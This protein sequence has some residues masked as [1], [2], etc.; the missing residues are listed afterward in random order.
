MRK[1]RLK[2]EPYYKEREEEERQK[3]EEE[4]A[5]IPEGTDVVYVDESGVQ[6]DMNPTHGRSKR[7]VKLYQEISGKRT[8]KK[9]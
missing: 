2:K 4:L 5:E 1:L 9:R 7:G 3:F 8:Y 6:K